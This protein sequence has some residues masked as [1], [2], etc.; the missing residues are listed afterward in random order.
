MRTGMSDSPQ[1][2]SARLTQSGILLCQSLF[3]SILLAASIRASGLADSIFYMPLLGGV[4]IFNS[5]LMYQRG[6]HNSA[7]A[8]WLSKCLFKG[9]AT[10]VSFAGVAISL[11][12]MTG[13]AIG[14]L[15]AAPVLICLPFAMTL[16][17]VSRETAS[18]STE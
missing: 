1:K 7:Y 5:V 18:E 6:L 13:D 15:Q 3:L 10:C 17:P 8:G 2:W 4:V 14:A 11:G 12:L 9:I 16:L